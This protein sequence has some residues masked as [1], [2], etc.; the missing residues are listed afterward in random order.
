M[1]TTI[2]E[3]RP[4]RL[5][6]LT[7]M[8]YGTGDWS[9]ASFNTLRTIFYAIFLTDVVGLEPRLASIAAF[10]GILWDA[11]NDPVVG[12]LSDR[13]K[14][15]WG[16]RRPF[17]L[18]FAVP[19]GLG[20][21][22]Q[23][24]SPP[25]DN[26]ITLMLTIM[27]AYM[28]C[29]TLQTL[30]SVPYF[31]LTPE[32]AD[33]YDQRTSLTGYRMFFNLFASLVT[34]VAAP[35]VVDNVVAGG[36]TPQQ[37]Y[38]TIAMILGAIAVVPF[39]LIFAFI[40]ERPITTTSQIAHV[41][42]RESLRAAWHNIPCRFATGIY[43]LTWLTIDFLSVLLPFFL[44]YWVAGG[45]TLAETSVLGI[46]LPI[47]SAFLGVLQLISIGS[48]PF[49]IWLAHKFSKR[50]AYMLAMTIWVG[51]QVAF[52]LVGQNQIGLA[53]LLAIPAGMGVAAGH[54]LP[55]SIYPDVIDWDE[56]RT[57]QRREGVYYGIKN[58]MRKV[59]SAV[60]I[61]VALQ[62]LGWTGYRAPQAGETVV[63]QPEAALTAMRMLITVV[64]ALL[65]FG[66]L[67]VAW[68][69]PLSRERHA[70]IR[71]LL[72]RKRAKQETVNRKR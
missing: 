30:V 40:R 41:S 18:W 61:F 7:K 68:F 59:T 42:L 5:S 29:D 23:W 22:L 62:V 33:D 19:F 49:W 51:T 28:V 1:A 60:A 54:V 71:L 58:L 56:L 26:Q 17:L 39:L 16:R 12:T 57:G 2:H 34:A 25:W 4:H 21:V 32:I 72:E 37:G 45:N 31:S 3:T 27:L 20:F 13:L 46:K 66:G 14:T 53:L 10:V 44:V 52:L 50:T 47:E 6:L 9:I 48:L 67:L 11:V 65:L 38:L 24:W 43:V 63:M 8:I 64:G 36:G 15:R 35:V 55:E 69:Y 70:E